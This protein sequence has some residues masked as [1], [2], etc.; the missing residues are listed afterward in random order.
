MLTGRSPFMAGSEY[1]IFK[2]ILSH[3]DNT[4]SSVSVKSTDSSVSVCTDSSVSV[5]TG[6]SVSVIEYPD[7]ISDCEKDFIESLL[8][9]N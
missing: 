6:S 4:D 2:K 9:G 7:F 1:L 5:C 8:K 3:A